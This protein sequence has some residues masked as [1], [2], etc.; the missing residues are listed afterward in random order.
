MLFRMSL[1]GVAPMGSVVCAVRELEAGGCGSK[2]T[3]LVI[4]RFPL[5]ISPIQLH[6]TLGPNRL[7]YTRQG[8]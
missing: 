1:W 3:Q 8:S 6:L 7:G 2:K 4:L 5:I